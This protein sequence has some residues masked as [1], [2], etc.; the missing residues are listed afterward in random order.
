MGENDQRPAN[1]VALF[2]TPNR[3]RSFLILGATPTPIQDRPK[4][5]QNEA[6]LGGLGSDRRASLIPNDQPAFP[7]FHVGVAIAPPPI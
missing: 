6:F 7:A 3:G 5:P 2:D 1:W 4:S